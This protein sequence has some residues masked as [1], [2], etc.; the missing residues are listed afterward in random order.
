MYYHNIYIPMKTESIPLAFC[1]KS[2]LCWLTIHVTYTIV[3]LANSQ[4][5]SVLFRT[6]QRSGECYIK[7]QIVFSVA[8]IV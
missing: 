5:H 1:L 7:L 3:Y 8:Y 4:L 6:L 2:T